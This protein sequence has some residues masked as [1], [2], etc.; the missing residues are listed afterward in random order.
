[1][2]KERF[3]ESK[4]I[5]SVRNPIE[6]AYSGYLSNELRVNN[7][8]TFREMID[9]HKK[10]IDEKKFFIYNILEPGFYSKHIRRFQDNFG[11]EK[12]KI[13]IFEEYIKKTEE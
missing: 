12:I 2:I 5:I 8:Q 10:L 3:P 7:N 4:I 9:E 13:I 11:K 1:M 6:R